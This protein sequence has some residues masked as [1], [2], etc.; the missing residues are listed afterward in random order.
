MVR[1]AIHRYFSPRY[2][3]QRCVAGDREV[4]LSGADDFEKG[5]LAS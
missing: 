2:F 4:I 1:E 5:L 3:D